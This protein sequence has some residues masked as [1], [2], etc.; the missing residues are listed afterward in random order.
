MEAAKRGKIKLFVAGAYF[1]V[2]W[3][4]VQSNSKFIVAGQASEKKCNFLTLL[5]K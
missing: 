5:T 3:A 1:Q 2:T 4:R